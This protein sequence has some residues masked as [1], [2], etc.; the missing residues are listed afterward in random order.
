MSMAYADDNSDRRNQPVVVPILIAINLLVFGIQ[1]MNLERSVFGWGMVPYEITHH[2]DLVGEFPL[3][4]GQNSLGLFDG[5]PAAKKSNEPTIVKYY[6]APLSVY[7]TLITAVFLHGGVMHVLGN[8][9]YLWIFGDQIEDRLGRV[10]F[11]IFYLACGLVANI[12]YVLVYPDSKIPT[13]GASGAIAAV[14]GGYVVLHP[15]KKVYVILFYQ[16]Y[17][18][19]AWIYHAIWFAMQT[20]GQFGIFGNGQVAYLAHISGFATGFVVFLVVR[21]LDWPKLPPAALELKETTNSRRL[22]HVTAAD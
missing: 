13:V 12:G 22:V 21:K 3:E 17:R 1:L 2:T 9:M 15:M 5:E 19:P 16:T 20:F 4:S 11:L 8:M 10:G 6:P 14:M 7:L 18:W